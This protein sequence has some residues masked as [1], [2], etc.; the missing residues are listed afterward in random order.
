MVILGGRCSVE[1]TAGSWADI[2]SREHVFDGLPTAVYLPLETQLTVSA[3]TDC[4]VA[5]CYSR[6][7]KTF[8]AR[9][10]LPDEIEVEVRGGDSIESGETA[11]VDA[12][13]AES[14]YRVLEEEVV[15]LYYDKDERGL[16]GK[17]IAMMK[18]AIKTLVPAFNSD[19]M[20]AEYAERI[21]S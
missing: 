8:P 9:L 11:D 6:A 16:P 13:D 14:L 1:S 15:P 19:R 5:L 4:E 7:E 2:G 20:V 17:W 21:Y 18:H 3:D 12:A 10:V